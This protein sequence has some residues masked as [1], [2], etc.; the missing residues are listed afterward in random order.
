MKTTTQ[1]AIENLAIARATKG[2]DAALAT[3]AAGRKTFV[4]GKPVMVAW[5][6][7]KRAEL[8]RLQLG[9]FDGLPLDADL[10]AH[11]TAEDVTDA[12]SE[13]RLL[14]EAADIYRTAGR[15]EVERRFA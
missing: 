9:A 11:Y 5:G 7:E 4:K 6:P 12:A 3:L 8:K 13:E 14:A 15:A 2:C 1:T 10:S